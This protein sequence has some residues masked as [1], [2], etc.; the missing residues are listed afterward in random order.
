MARRGRSGRARS[1][2]APVAVLRGL[3]AGV[4]AL[5]VFAA[6]LVALAPAATPAASAHPAAPGL[7]AGEHRYGPDFDSVK[8][9]ID[10]SGWP[11]QD[12]IWCG[13]AAMDAMINWK[14]PFISQHDLATWLNTAPA[15]SQWGAPSANPAIAWGPGFAAD[16]SRDVGTDP[17]SIAAGQSLLTKSSY[18]VV[19]DRISA[20]DATMHLIADLVRT[21]EPIHAIVFRDGHSVVISGVRATGDPVADPGSITVLEV[22]DPGFGIYNGNIQPAQMTLVSLD[23][24]YHNKYY[25]S[26]PYDEDYHGAIAQDPDPAI[27]PYTYDPDHGLGAHLWVGN[28]V[29][30]RPDQPGDPAASLSPDWALNQDGALIAGERGEFPD[31]WP[32]AV[33]ALDSDQRI[34]DAS[35]TLNSGGSG[36]QTHPAGSNGASQ[37][38]ISCSAAICKYFD[39]RYWWILGAPLLVLAG[40][41]VFAAMRA[42]ARTG[43]VVSDGRRRAAATKRRAAQ[44]SRLWDERWRDDAPGAVGTAWLDPPDWSDAPPHRPGQHGQHGS[45]G[46][47]GRT[48]ARIPRI[49][50]W[51]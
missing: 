6:T 18:H 37:P 4:L 10:A 2:L 1:P 25:W 51:E 46:H 12:H 40:L 22:W 27:G 5:A 9:A 7:R 43:R 34:R 45:S 41:L 15:R 32:G 50:D 11:Q 21:K 13:L 44:R 28:F 36:Q 23:D 3:V 39:P 35:P 17:R 8:R 30:I 16:I 47:S 19:V 14:K 31:Q 29:Y 24:W 42:E 20:Q 26:T 48:T 38:F 33:V 49:E